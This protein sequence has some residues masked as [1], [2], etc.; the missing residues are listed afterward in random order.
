MDTIAVKKMVI[1]AMIITV[2][3]MEP[4]KTEHR[5]RNIYLLQNPGN[6][7]RSMKS[8]KRTV[9]TILVMEPE[10]RTIL[11]ILHSRKSRM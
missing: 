11:T 4:E 8:E 1:A 9:L 3:V 6:L 5:W 10:K 2:M 7:N